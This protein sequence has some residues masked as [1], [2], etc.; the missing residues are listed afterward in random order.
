[1]ESLGDPLDQV[2]RVVGFVVAEDARGA[3]VVDRFVSVSR[4]EADPAPRVVMSLD[5]RGDGIRQ[6]IGVGVKPVR[7]D[8]V[9]DE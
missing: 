1:L 4:G 2:D 3:R 8:R 9:A 6:R 7:L 5:P